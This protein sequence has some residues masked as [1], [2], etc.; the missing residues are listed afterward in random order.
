[1]HAE[2]SPDLRVIR[3]TIESDEAVEYEDLLAALPLPGDDLQRQRTFPGRPDPGTVRWTCDGLACSFETTLPR[4]YGD[5]GVEP[6]KNLWANGAW[7]PVVRGAPAATWTVSLALPEGTTGVVN[8]QVSAG[9]LDYAGSSDRLAL[10]VVGGRNAL[11]ARVAVGDA[12]RATVIGRAARRPVVEQELTAIMGERRPFGEPV[13]IVVVATRHRQRLATSGPGVVYLSDRAFRVS[14]GLHAFHWAAVRRAVYA[15]VAPFAAT[16]DREFAAAAMAEGAPGPRADRALG[17]AAWNPIVDAL[18]TDGTLPFYEDVFDKTH[19]VVTDPYLRGLR[20]PRAAARQLHALG[21]E[22]P[23]TW[24]VEAAGSAETVLAAAQRLGNDP[25]A[26][27]WLQAPED[28]DQDFRLCEPDSRGQVRVCRDGGTGEQPVVLE[29]DGVRTTVTFPAGPSSVPVAEGSRRV[30]VDP[31]AA[32]LDG[33][34]SN[35]R[36]PARWSVVATGWI[37]DISPSQQSFV[38]WGNLVFRRR[39]DTHNLFVLGLD[40]DARDLVSASVGYL[41]SLGPLVNRRA[42]QHRLYFVAGPTVFDPAYHDVSGGQFAVEGGVTYAWDTRGSDTYATEGQR[43]AVGVNGGTVVDG[44][45]HWAGAGATHV[46]LLP[47][48]PAHVVASRLRAGWASG[49]VEHRLLSLG[50]AENLRSIGNG[51]GL[52]NE[53]LVANLDYRWAPLRDASVPLGLGWLAQLQLVPGVEAGVSWIGRGDDVS[54]AEGSSHAAAAGTTLGLYAVVDALGARP[55][56][57]G[58]VGAIPFWVLNVPD[59]GPQVYLS[60]DHAF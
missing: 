45:A 34:R 16:W 14:P 33:D 53:R 22:L 19:G 4:R 46:L 8:G 52:G 13:D 1:M 6:G 17:W 39:D 50:G 24:A 5:I 30:V 27:H 31:D 35:N 43:L 10:A 9:R 3:G 32:V 55:T 26:L 7:Y 59:E 58:A 40:H 21:P 49:A 20:E 42:R 56:L 41:R 12:G 57:V 51:E 48:H 36:F 15:A 47:L 60:F 11:P 2:V 25:A 44:G 54:S 23:S 29:H 38:A 28:S 37:D 18:L